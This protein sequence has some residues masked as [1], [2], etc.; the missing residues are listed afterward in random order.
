M[1]EYIR[2]YFDTGDLHELNSLGSKGWEVIIVMDTSLPDNKS[3]RVG[4]LFLMAILKR[5][6]KC[7]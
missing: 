6:I 1:F 4:S 2:T 5:K 3:N 7:T